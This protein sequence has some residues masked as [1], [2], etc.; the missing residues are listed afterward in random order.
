MTEST[1]AVL[2][3]NGGIYFMIIKILNVS[4]PALLVVKSV[5]VHRAAIEATHRRVSWYGV[6]I[7]TVATGTLYNMVEKH[8]F[9][10]GDK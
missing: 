9:I 6:R 8:Q 7:T 1:T 4:I 2:Y 10:K 3:C 5:E